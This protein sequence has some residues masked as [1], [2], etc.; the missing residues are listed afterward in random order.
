MTY[1]LDTHYMIWAITDTKKLSKKLNET[2][3]D[4]DNRIII[5]TISFWEVSLKTALGKLKITGFSPEDLPAICEE[6]GFDIKP[7]SAKESCAYHK[8]GAG[9]H[10]DPFDRMLIWQAISNDYILV[11]ADGH[12]KKYTSE[13]L[14]IYQER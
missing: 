9:Y 8:L 1:L 13:G 12:V 7:L 10:K 11:S 4:P 14:R 6:M 5:S 3:I 2:L